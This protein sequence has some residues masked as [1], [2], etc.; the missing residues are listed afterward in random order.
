MMRQLLD[1][2]ETAEQLYLM[3]APPSQQPSS[4]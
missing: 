1:R 2:E 3:G 4:Q